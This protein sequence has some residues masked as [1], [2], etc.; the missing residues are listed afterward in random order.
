MRSKGE[1]RWG[2]EGKEV[3]SAFSW[4]QPSPKDEDRNRT[5]AEKPGGFGGSLS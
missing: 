2:G 3:S 1:A 5:N 4:L